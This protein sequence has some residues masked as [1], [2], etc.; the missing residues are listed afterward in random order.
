MPDICIQ[1]NAFRD[2][3]RLIGDNTASKKVSKIMKVLRRHPQ[4][5]DKI[6]VLVFYLPDEEL[7]ANFLFQFLVLRS[8]IIN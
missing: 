1:F 2:L 8:I 3:V 5:Y 6:K 7:F 4:N